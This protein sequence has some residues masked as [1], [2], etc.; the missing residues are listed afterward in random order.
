MPKPISVIPEGELREA[1]D[2]ET[3]AALDAGILSE[4]TGRTYTWEEAKKFARERRKA[5][6]TIP[7]DLKQQS[8]SLKQP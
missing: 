2:A 7:N 1:L 8:S 3:L 6:M 4:E 5:W